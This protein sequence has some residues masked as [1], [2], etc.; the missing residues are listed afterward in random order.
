VRPEAA[1]SVACRIGDG[2]LARLMSRG[3]VFSRQE[4]EGAIADSW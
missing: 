3:G 4:D 1:F 2:L